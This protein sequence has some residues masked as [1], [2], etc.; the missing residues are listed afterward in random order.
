MT[1][2]N[3]HTRYMDVDL[4]LVFFTKNQL[5]FQQHVYQEQSTLD[6][7]SRVLEDATKW[8]VNLAFFNK[9]VEK[10]GKSELISI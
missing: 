9:I 3:F 8:I 10:F 2:F 1:C 5:E 4:L 7:Q 6:N